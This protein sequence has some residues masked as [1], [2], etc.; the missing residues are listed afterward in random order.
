MVDTAYKT[1]LRFKLVL[2]VLSKGDM[3]TLELKKETNIPPSTIYKMINE[4]RINEVVKVKGGRFTDNQMTHKET[5]W[6]LIKDGKKTV[7]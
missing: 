5:I 1:Y 4:L 6:G 3:T 7:S 2:E